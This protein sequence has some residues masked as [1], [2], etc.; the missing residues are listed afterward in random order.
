MSG[1]SGE[2]IRNAQRCG[3]SKERRV[4]SADMIWDLGGK[5]IVSTKP[6]VDIR[7]SNLMPI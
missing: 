3:T 1:I 2:E 5:W 6:F 4:F 7:Y